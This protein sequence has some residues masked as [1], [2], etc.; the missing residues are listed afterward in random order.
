M[1]SSTIDQDPK[2]SNSLILM[3][4]GNVGRKCLEVSPGNGSNP[5]DDRL[6]NH[7]QTTLEST[8]T[9]KSKHRPNKSRK[10]N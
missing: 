6:L 1:V 4:Q 9:A 10:M 8:Q 2:L 3:F 5:A 7:S